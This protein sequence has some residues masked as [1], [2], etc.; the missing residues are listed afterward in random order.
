ME[1]HETRMLFDIFDEQ[2]TAERKKWFVLQLLQNL[3]LRNSTLVK[4]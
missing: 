2:C 3:L 4:V 1:L